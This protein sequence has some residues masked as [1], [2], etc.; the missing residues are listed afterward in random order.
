MSVELAATDAAARIAAIGP[1]RIGGPERTRLLALI[2]AATAAGQPTPGAAELK[3]ESCLPR[4]GVELLLLML[5]RDGWLRWQPGP[6]GS[7][8][9]VLGARVGER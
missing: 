3:R 2:A 9:Y 6:R 5:R 8:R 4:E 1:E 7:D